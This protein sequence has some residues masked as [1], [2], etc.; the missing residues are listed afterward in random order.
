MQPSE[1]KNGSEDINSK[2]KGDNKINSHNGFSLRKI[3]LIQ[4]AL[5]IRQPQLVTEEKA[6]SLSLFIVTKSRQ[7]VLTIHLNVSL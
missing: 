4:I 5:R 1:W 2:I 3:F 7:V 6:Y